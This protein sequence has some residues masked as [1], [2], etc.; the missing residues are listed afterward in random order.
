M[1]LEEGDVCGRD[2]CN[3]FM[4]YPPVQNCSCHIRPPCGQCLDN[5][6]ECTVCHAGPDDEETDEKGFLIG[7]NPHSGAEP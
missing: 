5:E 4:H 1:T 2:G 6:L 7:F 3:G